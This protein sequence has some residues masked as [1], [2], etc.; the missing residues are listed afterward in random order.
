V[1]WRYCVDQEKKIVFAAVS[2]AT[3]NNVQS[4][5]ATSKTDFYGISDIEYSL[6]I[7]WP[8]RLDF[9]R[10]TNPSFNVEISFFFRN[11]L[12][13][14]SILQIIKFLNLLIFSPKLKLKILFY[15]MDNKRMVN[16]NVTHF[17]SIK[18]LSYIVV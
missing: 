2:T 8:T 3:L 6:I 4:P 9:F 17:T 16:D 11:L 1:F 14:K 13:Q 12:S 18:P 7:V 5:C 10:L 15:D